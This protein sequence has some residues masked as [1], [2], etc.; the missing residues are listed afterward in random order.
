[1]KAWRARGHGRGGR[2]AGAS[3]GWGPRPGAAE[4]RLLLL[5]E[6]FREQGPRWPRRRA[7]ARGGELGEERQ[8]TG[9]QRRDVQNAGR[10]GGWGERPPGLVDGDVAAGR[11]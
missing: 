7:S 1:M 4:G 3:W 6:E 10:R 5:M 2:G 11:S 8:R 9:T